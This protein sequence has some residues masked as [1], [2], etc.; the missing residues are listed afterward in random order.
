MPALAQTTLGEICFAVQHHCNVFV[1]VGKQARADAGART[2]RGRQVAVTL[3]RNS[4][5]EL[6]AGAENSA[7]LVALMLGVAHGESVVGRHCCTRCVHKA[8]D[9]AAGLATVS[10]P[11]PVVYQN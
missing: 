9:P 5:Y 6:L 10:D 7:S 1:F 11:L 4:L 3:T 2:S 8:S